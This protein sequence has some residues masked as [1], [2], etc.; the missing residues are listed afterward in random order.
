[1]IY[2]KPQRFYTLQYSNYDKSITTTV[3]DLKSIIVIENR[4]NDIL[5]HLGKDHICIGYPPETPSHEEFTKLC[6]AWTSYKT[7]SD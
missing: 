5:I 2:T 3:L 7:I 1:M 4:S 6:Q